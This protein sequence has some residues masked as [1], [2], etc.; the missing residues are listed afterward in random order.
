MRNYQMVEMPS[1][2]RQVVTSLRNWV[3]GNGSIAHEETQFLDYDHDL[4][5]TAKGTDGAM[6]LLQP[7]IEAIT[8]RIYKLFRKRAPT[9]ISRDEHIYIF[10]EPVLHL[11]TRTLI[12]W[13]LVAIIPVPIVIMQAISSNLP[14]VLCT[15]FAM[16]FLLV[17]ISCLSNARTTEIFIAAATYATV[18]VV[19]LAGGGPA[20]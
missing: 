18:L 10:S 13:V 19:F 16:L 1:A 4:F 11:A 20:V 5:T 14:R 6:S 3:E 12:A 2:P 15:F 8:I 7:W 17:G 9:D